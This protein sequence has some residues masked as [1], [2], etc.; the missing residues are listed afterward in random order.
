[1]GGDDAVAPQAERAHVRQV[2]LAATLGDGDDVIGIPEALAAWRNVALAAHRLL[3]GPALVADAPHQGDG[4]EAAEGADTAIAGENLVAQ[5]AGIGAQLPL[6]DAV[7]AAERPPPLGYLGVAPA[8]ETAT[9]GTARGAAA[10]PAG[11]RT[12]AKHAHGKASRFT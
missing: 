6:V 1:M 2:A 7:I 9:V 4:V 3:H 10:H 5:V 8:A 12:G 11:G